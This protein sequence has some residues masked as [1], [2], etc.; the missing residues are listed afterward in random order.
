MTTEHVSVPRELANYLKYHFRDTTTLYTT[1]KYI[2]DCVT[3][4][5]EANHVGVRRLL[6][7]RNAVTCKIHL[8]RTAQD[9][10]DFAKRCM[11]DAKR[12]KSEG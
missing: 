1:K 6:K 4:A 3:M 11:A 7:S 12:A 9:R 10:F 2:K 8:I 5:R